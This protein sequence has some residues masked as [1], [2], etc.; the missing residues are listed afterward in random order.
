MCDEEDTSRHTD[1]D[2]GAAAD[3]ALTLHDPLDAGVGPIGSAV[4]TFCLVRRAAAGRRGRLT[5]PVPVRAG[6]PEGARGTARA[7]TTDVQPDD[8]RSPYG[9]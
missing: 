8:G 1:A 5:C 7:P 2:R 3:G 4:E 6:R 9:G